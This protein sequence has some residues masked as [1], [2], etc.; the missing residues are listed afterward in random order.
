[1]DYYCTLDIADKLSLLNQ[2]QKTQSLGQVKVQASGDRVSTE[3]D[4][5]DSTAREEIVHLMDSIREDP[6]FTS[7]MPFY[8][9][10]MAQAR[11]GQTIPI[12]VSSPR[13]NYDP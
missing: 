13:W 11:P 12:Y 10:I 1:M 3:F 8:D 6:N 7:D 4:T 5:G 2:L 9:A